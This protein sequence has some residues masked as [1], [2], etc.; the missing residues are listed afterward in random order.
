LIFNIINPHKMKY[1]LKF[2]SLITFMLV[3]LASCSKKLDLYP[4]NAK[5]PSEIFSTVDGYKSVLAKLYATLSVTGA[6]GPAGS[7]DIGGGL[8]EGSQVGF[9]R[10]YFNLEE[11]PTDEA[12]VAW[13]DQTIWD[14]HNLK[15]TSGDPFLK[16][17]Y[18]RP[19]W[20]I[21]LI[22]E[23]MRQATDD[24]L[25]KNGITGADATAVKNTRGE[26]RFLR[27]FNYWLM[28]N[29]FG[30]STFITEA[31]GAGYF[32]PKEI[33]R[34]DLFTYIE[35][36]LKTAEGE[37]AAAKTAEYGRVDQGAAWAL[38]A[39]LYLNAGVYTGANRYTDAITYAKK[40]IAAGY[41]LNPNYRQ[42][43]MADNDRTSKDE[44]IFVATCDG[45]NSKSFAN[46]TFLIHAP[47]GAD[48]PE[49]GANN[50]WFG[51]RATKAF[52]ALWPDLTGA[53]DKR[54]M[55][56]TSEFA[57]TMAQAEINDISDFSNGLHV[58]KYKNIRADGGKVSDPNSEFADIDFPIIRLPE[59]YFIYA[60]S[61]LRGGTGGDAAT[62]LGYINSL[63][64]RATTTTISAG[65]MT[66]QFLLDE[67]ARE[68]Y[69]EGHR[70]TDLIRYGLLTTGS[71]LW[72]WKGG[73]A[74]GSSVNS[75]FNIYPVPAANINSNKNLTQNA[76]Y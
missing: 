46:T 41:K 50:G 39:R 72:P 15:W 67:R 29:W 56:Q 22:N 47:A 52:A 8:D 58:V 54:A 30:K 18:A 66:L 48:N 51:Y 38:L 40:V 26:A 69:W 2:F 43:F 73:V 60:E 28:L 33:S 76:G 10:A 14:F 1:N 11:L 16:G 35:T 65:D 27:A 12:V 37:L 19:I 75:K 57:A 59:M 13:N 6:D 64:T 45:L 21:T 71:Y 20:N 23:Y 17:A 4:S 32:L 31:D 63:R 3:L 9:I 7:P 25:A 62:A 34:A 42:L 44:F 55:F 5:S 61:V 70:R 49:Y 53:T 24:V 74:S 68:L 36:E